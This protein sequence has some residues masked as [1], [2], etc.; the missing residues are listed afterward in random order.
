MIINLSENS[1][2]VRNYV[3][4]LRDKEVQKDRARFRFNMRRI[5][6]IMGYEISKQMP[7]RSKPVQTPMATADGYYLSEQPVLA[8][9]LRA[10]L[11]LHEGLQVTFDQADCAYVSAYRKHVEDG[12]FEIE[13]G[14]VS[15][16]EINGRQ[17][18]VS[19]PMLATGA[20]MVTTLRKFFELGQPEQTYIV[21]AVA[22]EP[23][24]NYVLSELDDV[25]IYTGAIDPGLDNKSY[26]VPGLGDAGDLSYGPKIQ[27]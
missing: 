13:M 27:K 1:S 24:I 7:Y 11:A 16:P 20:S 15:S 2:I 23:G 12:T 8:T 25:V 17:L 19:D 9:I 4:E 10:G 21:T 6:Q 18:I 14:Y 3:T 5:G 26:I 22:S